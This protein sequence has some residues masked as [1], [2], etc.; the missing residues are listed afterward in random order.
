MC[1]ALEELMKEEFEEKKKEGEKL[2]REAGEILKLIS[3]VC[4]KLVKG[5]NIAEIAEDLEETEE[6]IGQI[7]NMARKYAPDYNVDEIYKKLYQKK[8]SCNKATFG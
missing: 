5:K 3:I 1:Q 6:V 4:K 8:D 2:G 7:C